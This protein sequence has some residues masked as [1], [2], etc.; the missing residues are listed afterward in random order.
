MPLNDNVLW[1][2]GEFQTMT[3]A[4]CLAFWVG[5]M[6]YLYSTVMNGG[7]FEKK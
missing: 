6:V 7:L 5:A 3:A 2:P 4:L 1:G